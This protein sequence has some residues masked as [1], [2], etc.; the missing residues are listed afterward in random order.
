MHAQDAAR[1]QG[2]LV[3]SGLLE[4]ILG[5]TLPGKLLRAGPRSRLHALDAVHHAVG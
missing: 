4:Q 5:R 3:S 1:P 2:Q